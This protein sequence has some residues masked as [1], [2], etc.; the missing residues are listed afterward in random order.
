M[1]VPVQILPASIADDLA[2][3]EEESK[4][5]DSS[6][7]YYAWDISTKKWSKV[8]SNNSLW[9]FQGGYYFFILDNNGNNCCYLLD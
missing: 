1:N 5:S 3:Y 2:S 7:N 6:A 4:Y 8:S 9:R